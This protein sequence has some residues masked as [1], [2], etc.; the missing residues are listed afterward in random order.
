M[1]RQS[2]FI[3]WLEDTEQGSSEP[4][5]MPNPSIELTSNG[6]RPSATAHVKR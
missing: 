5:L 2:P 3:G 6:L 1:A 4:A